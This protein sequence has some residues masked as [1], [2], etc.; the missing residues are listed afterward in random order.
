[1]ERKQAEEHGSVVIAIRLEDSFLPSV[2]AGSWRHAVNLAELAVCVNGFRI[3][4]GNL[5]S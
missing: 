5:K 4:S 3:R 1:V 2:K